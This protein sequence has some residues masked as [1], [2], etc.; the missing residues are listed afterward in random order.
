LEDIPEYN[1]ST[2]EYKSYTK[3]IPTPDKNLSAFASFGVSFMVYT[4]VFMRVGVNSLY[5]LSDLMY[6]ESR[7]P[8]DFYATTGKDGEKTNLLSTGVEVGLYYRILSGAK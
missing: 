1:F 6:R 4:D 8:V 2:T 3:S 5:G 7:H